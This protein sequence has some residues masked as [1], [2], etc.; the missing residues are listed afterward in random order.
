MFLELDFENVSHFFA[1]K[2][3]Y[4]QNPAGLTW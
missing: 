1:F 4:G 3:M 2:K